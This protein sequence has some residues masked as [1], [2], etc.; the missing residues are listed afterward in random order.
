MYVLSA[1]FWLSAVSICFG[2]LVTLG[3]TNQNSLVDFKRVCLALP[4]GLV[5]SEPSEKLKL[6]GYRPIGHGP[7]GSC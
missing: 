4:I 6:K 3:A 5:K 1:L 7:S 2:G